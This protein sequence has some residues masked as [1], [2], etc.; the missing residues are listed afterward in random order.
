MKLDINDSILYKID[1]IVW[2]EGIDEACNAR[3]DQILAAKGGNVFFNKI[4][5]GNHTYDS[6]SKK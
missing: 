5:H 3:S 2:H 6:S 1:S 4:L